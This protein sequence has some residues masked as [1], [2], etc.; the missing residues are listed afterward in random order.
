MQDLKS[1]IEKAILRFQN[2]SAGLMLDQKTVDSLSILSSE[3]KS[4]EAFESISKDPY[5]PKWGSPWWKVLLLYESGYKH[6]IP[7][8]FLDKLIRIIDSHYLHWF[9]LL[10]S[11]LPENCDAYR[12]VL[13]HCALG[14]IYK[15]LEECGFEVRTKLPWWC[16]W[17]GKYQLPDGGYNCDEAAY[18]RSKKSSFLSTLPMLEAMLTV[19]KKTGDL[20]VKGLLD[21]GAQYLISHNIYKSSTAK[22]ITE[23]WFKISFPHY[24]DYDVLLGFSFIVDWALITG[25][26]LPYELVTDCIDQ[27]EKSVNADGYVVLSSNKLEKV[28]SLFYRQNQWIWDDKSETFPALVLFSKAGEVSITLTIKWYETIT[29]LQSLNVR[30]V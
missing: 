6:M 25:A 14:N 19:Y 26:E 10:E 24:Y 29:R 16:E 4:A 27:I 9:P 30:T 18:T 12:D 7:L 1:K 2:I 3:L 22:I 8:E 28:G 17:L 11:E 15:V 5:W 13:C 21:K 23:E 20:W